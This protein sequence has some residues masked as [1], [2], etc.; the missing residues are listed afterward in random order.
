[1]KKLLFTLLFGVALVACGDEEFDSSQL[2]ASEDYGFFDDVADGFEDLL[3]IQ[4]K[5][6][7]GHLGHDC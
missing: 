6:T 7:I 3:T 4:C 2:S 5:G 1:M